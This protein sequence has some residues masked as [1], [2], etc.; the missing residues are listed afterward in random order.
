MSRIFPSFSACP[1]VKHLGESLHPGKRWKLQWNNTSWRCISYEVWGPYKRPKINGQLGLSLTPIS[2][3][4]VV[5][6]PT[7]NCFLGPPCM[8]KN[9][10]FPA[11][12][13]FGVNTLHLRLGD[14]VLH[15]ELSGHFCAK[16]TKR[17]RVPIPITLSW[18]GTPSSFS[19]N[20]SAWIPWC[21]FF[22]LLFLDFRGSNNKP[23]A[24]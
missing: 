11:M 5:T 22:G 7:C 15:Q 23:K 2:F 19:N 4:G 17:L 18:L 14:H 8:K 16:K 6:N 13:V 1:K 3:R 12:L 24:I 21:V 20:I 10:D 9:G